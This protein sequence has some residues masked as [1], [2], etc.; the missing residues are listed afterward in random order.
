MPQTGLVCG[1][2]TVLL[3]GECFLPAFYT[4]HAS[5]K[6]MQHARRT[7][8]KKAAYTPNVTSDPYRFCNSE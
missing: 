6:K 7:T 5:Y 3:H 1:R 8:S 2:N 4:P